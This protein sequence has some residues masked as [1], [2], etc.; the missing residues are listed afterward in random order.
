MPVDAQPDFPPADRKYHNYAELIEHV[1]AVAAARP[2]IVR[3]FTIGLSYE[4]RALCAAEVTRTPGTT[5]L[6]P[7]VLVDGLHHASEYMSSEM[8]LNLLD[9]LPNNAGRDTPLGKRVSRILDTRRVWIVFMV[10][11]DGF[12]PS[13]PGTPGYVPWRKNRQ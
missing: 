3:L 13:I 6:M 11:P 10:N 2:D 5:V 7:E 4:G 1:N 12:E 8:T 9:V